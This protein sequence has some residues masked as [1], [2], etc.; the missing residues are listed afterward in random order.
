MPKRQDESIKIVDP[1]IALLRSRGWI[2]H[3]IVA[4]ASM[5]GLGD[6]FCYNEEL[7]LHR[8]IEFKHFKG[9]GTCT[10]ITEAQEKLF[11][12]QYKAG[13]P[14]YCVADWDLRGEDNYNKRLKHY[15]RICNSPP[16]IMNLVD[17]S[18]RRYL[19]VQ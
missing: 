14:L 17:P 6:Y 3:N 5:F 7:E 1:F 16:N 18:R 8:F 15:H 12:I 9:K 19:P 2:C 11:P 13:V 10:K 4:D